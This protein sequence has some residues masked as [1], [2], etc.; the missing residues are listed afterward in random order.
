MIGTFAALIGAV[1]N[2]ITMIYIRKVSA[3]VKS[4]VM[5]FYWALGNSFLV[6]LLYFGTFP[7]KGMTTSYTKET[8]L[9]L[10]ACSVLCCL[11]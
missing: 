1:F 6:P 11:G 2:G 3:Y 10:I 5:I 8:Y 4:S 7:F 9:F